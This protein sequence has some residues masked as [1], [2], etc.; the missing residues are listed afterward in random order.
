MT[1][2]FLM[3]ILLSWVMVSFFLVLLRRGKC[4]V[5][6]DLPRLA[7][8][9]SEVVYQVEV[10]NTGSSSLSG[11]LL[12][13]EERDV[14]PTKSEFLNSREPDEELRNG[15]DRLFGYYR[16]LWICEKKRQR[17]VKPHLLDSIKSGE[18]R[19]IT[20]KCVPLKRGKISFAYMKLVLPDPLG[21]FQRWRSVEQTEDCL[22]VLPKRYRLPD[23]DLSGVSRNQ[24][25]G[26]VASQSAGQVGEFIGL[27]D[28]KPG[29]PLKLMHWRSYA[30]TGKPIVK[31]YEDVFFPRCGLVLDTCCALQDAEK[32]EEAVSIA[33]S[34]ASSVDTKESLLDLI[35]LNQGAKVQT[36]G[37]GVAKVEQMLETL[38]SVEVDLDPDWHSLS[39]K[40]LVHAEQLSTCIVILTSVS[41]EKTEMVQRW[42]NAGM[43]L[44]VLVLCSSDSEI[45]IANSHGYLPISTQNVQR[46]LMRLV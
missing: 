24:M 15:F 18:A 8:A 23:F 45:S 5:R 9:G 11:A 43:G 25:G 34:F 16:W 26:E 13:D 12:V 29:D 17:E 32:F 1:G 20:M 4:S 6:R 31:E 2:F 7:T 44:L 27:R 30:K 10:K 19:R 21:L 35:F 41:D 33:A 22:V 39:Q 37:K 3:S 36:V 38:A 28:Y 40:V 14:R 46:D 42:R